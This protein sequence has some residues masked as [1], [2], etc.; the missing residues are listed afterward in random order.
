M[1]PQPLTW[2]RRSEAGLAVITADNGE[3]TWRI[4]PVPRDVVRIHYKGCDAD[5]TL[6]MPM[7]NQAYAESVNEAMIVIDVLR[8]GTDH[9]PDWREQLEAA[10]F[11]RTYPDEE[12][13]STLSCLWR[14]SRR[15]GLFQIAVKDGYAY[16]DGTIETSVHATY[17]SGRAAFWHNVSRVTAA[18]QQR[19]TH[20]AVAMRDGLPEGVDAL[21]AGVA[22]AIAIRAARRARGGRFA[23]P[24]GGAPRSPR[25]A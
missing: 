21:K 13:G 8:V 24:I 3:A 11:E 17:E 12:H 18:Q 9:L 25:E 19:R 10:G 14:D 6:V 20:G 7:D 23:D 22:A 5:G 1:T 16:P 2:T 4:T 15:N